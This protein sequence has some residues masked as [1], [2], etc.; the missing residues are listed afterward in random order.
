MTNEQLIDVIMKLQGSLITKQ[1]ELIN[2]NMSLEKNL[3]LSKQN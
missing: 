1:T 2:D 3:I